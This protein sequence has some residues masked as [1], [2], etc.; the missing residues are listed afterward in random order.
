[1]L[2]LQVLLHNA[3]HIFPGRRRPTTPPQATGSLPVL[4]EELAVAAVMVF[5]MIFHQLL[6]QAFATFRGQA[7]LL[8]LLQTR[9]LP[10][11]LSPPSPCYLVRPP[12]ILMSRLLT[13]FPTA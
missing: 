8:L 6:A 9:I 7:T 1:M 12:T 13:P 5:L 3:H 2:L 10:H 4:R 11:T